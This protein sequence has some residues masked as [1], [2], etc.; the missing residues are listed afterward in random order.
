MQPSVLI[1]LGVENDWDKFV[2]SLNILVGPACAL[3]LN[4]ADFGRYGKSTADVGIAASIAIFA[5]SVVVMLIGGVLMKSGAALMTDYYI[6]VAGMDPDM[7]RARVLQSPDSIAATFMVFGG[8]VGFILMV[9]AQA[10]AQVLNS[11]SSSLC[12][13]NLADAVFRWRPGRVV[14]VVLANIIALVMLYG[15][16]LDTADGRAA[17]RIGQCHY[18]GLLLCRPA[19][20]IR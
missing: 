5:Q 17:E 16:I 13:A 9:F 8:L 10:K 7:A 20:G 4:T 1:G 3:A 2:F 18:H 11:Y 14:F 19:A 15:H 12:I 6:N